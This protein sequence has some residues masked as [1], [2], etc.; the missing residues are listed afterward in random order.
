MTLISRKALPPGVLWLN[1]KLPN[2]KMQ[3]GIFYMTGKAVAGVML[4]LSSPSPPWQDNLCLLSF[5]IFS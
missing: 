2:S 4:Q 3:S 1:I 5:L